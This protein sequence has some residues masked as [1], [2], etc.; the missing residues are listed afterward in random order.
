LKKKFDL[1]T[2][3]SSNALLRREN[4]RGKIHITSSAQSNAEVGKT[5]DKDTAIRQAT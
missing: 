4:L 5:N 1:S 3:N 2:M